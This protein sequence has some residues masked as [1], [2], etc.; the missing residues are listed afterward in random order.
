MYPANDYAEQ[1]ADEMS[2]T[3]GAIFSLSAEGVASPH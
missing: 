3:K 2:L 1:T